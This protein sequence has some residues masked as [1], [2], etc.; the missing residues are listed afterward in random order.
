MG[1]LIA[2]FGGL[3]MGAIFGILVMTIVIGS[4]IERGDDDL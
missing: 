3:F 4:K 1:E 2:F